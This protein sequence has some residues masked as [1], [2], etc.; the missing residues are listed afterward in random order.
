M[1]RHMNRHPFNRDAI[2]RIRKGATARDLGW[3]ETFYVRVCRQHALPMMPSVEPTPVMELQP[4]AATI[5]PLAQA[6]KSPPP[7]VPVVAVAI[8][9][10]PTADGLVIVD[11]AARD[12]RRGAASIELTRKQIIVVAT[13]ARAA[14][15]EYVAKQAIAPPLDIPASSVGNYIYPVRAALRHLKVYLDS[16]KGRGCG[17]YR[18]LDAVTL[19]PLKCQV[20]GEAKR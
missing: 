5:E 18:L 14:P 16:A 10:T 13:L 6:L 19:E 8:P 9:R 12:V 3:D 15:H 17:G 20:I 11:V 2:A 4:V 7:L 1:N